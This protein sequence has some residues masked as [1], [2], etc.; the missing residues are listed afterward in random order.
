MYGVDFGETRG[1]VPDN[2]GP[3]FRAE[4]IDVVGYALPPDSTSVPWQPPAEQ[5][6]VC[7]PGTY[8]EW[9]ERA[10]RWGCT[11][12]PGYVVDP[13]GALY[14]PAAQR[15]T[16]LA[17]TL[18]LPMFIGG[19]QGVVVFEEIENR[20]SGGVRFGT[21]PQVVFPNGGRM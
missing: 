14:P 13:E 21:L 6:P 15:P 19:H 8:S 17:P 9:S 20:Q 4:Y 1:V 18:M 2:V 12:T 10:E 11:A 7:P 16:S 5:R 3:S